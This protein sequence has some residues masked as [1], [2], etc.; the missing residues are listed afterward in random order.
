MVAA[1]LTD[2]KVQD[3]GFTDDDDVNHLS[4][5]PGFDG[6][7]DKRYDNRFETSNEIKR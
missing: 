7:Y 2:F 4:Y 3:G 5:K 6:R 1:L